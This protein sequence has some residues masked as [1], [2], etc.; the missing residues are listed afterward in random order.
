VAA[1]FDSGVAAF[2]PIDV[3]LYNAGARVRG[4]IVEL[5]PEKVEQALAANAFGGFLAQSAARELEV[6]PWIERF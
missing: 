1:L 5:D 6:R 4:A 2:G 3:V